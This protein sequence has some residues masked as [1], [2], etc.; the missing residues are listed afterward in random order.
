MI[1]RTAILGA[2][3]F[4][5]SVTSTVDARP[6]A[7]PAAPQPP[8][9]Q[10]ALTALDKLAQMGYSVDT[11]AHAL[12]AIRHWQKVNGLVVD[13]IIGP[14]TLASLD[15]GASASATAIRVNPPAR[16]VEQIIRDAWPDDS[17]D[18]AVAIATRESRLVPTARNSCCYGLFQINFA[19]HRAWLADMGITSASQLLDA[20]TNVRAALALFEAAGWSPWQL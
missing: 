11:Q 16:S 5:T 1:R 10:R 18:H 17:E 13:G 4:L 12:R 3:V 2:A 8:S 6:A 19:P 9:V 20:E 14:Q 7:V 15:L